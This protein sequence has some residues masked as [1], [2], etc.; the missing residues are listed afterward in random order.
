V[1]GYSLK[2]PTVPNL[3]EICGV[4]G[5]VTSIN[6]DVRDLESLKCVLYKYMPEVVIHMAAQS[7]VRYSFK[8]P[9]ET[10]ETNILGT[11]NVLEAC[12][13]TPSVRVILNVTSDKCYENREGVR[14]VREDDPMGGYDPYSSSK[15]CAE[16]VSNAYARSFFN[17]GDYQKHGK[18]LATVRAGNV[19][20][21]GDWAEDR[22]IPDCVRAFMEEKPIAVRYPDAVRPW[23]HVLEP[24][25]G[26][27]LLAKC[28][29]KEGALF[30]G[31][32]NFGPDE[33]GAKSVAW[34]VEKVTALW[35]D[36]AAWSVD[37]RNNP[38]EAHYLQLDCSKAK[39]KLGWYPSL[40]TGSALEQTVAWYKAYWNG[41]D[42]FDFSIAQIE[43]Y[44]SLVRKKCISSRKV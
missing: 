5:R 32:W 31:G 12:R 13:N 16:L 28:L 27:L 9:V 4:E 21:G 1:I 40:D 34:V 18:A 39:S 3:F 6:G 17:P 20:G 22:L 33:G 23:Q 36:T 35:G 25:Y 14:G 8:E 26:Y 41:E 30:S 7:L 29:Y 19:I 42:M 37:K 11:V 2:P 15:G 24:L 44:E 10:Y 38:H 43:S